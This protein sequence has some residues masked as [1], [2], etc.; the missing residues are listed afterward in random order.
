MIRKQFADPSLMAKAAAMDLAST[1]KHL[2]QTKPAVHIALTGGTS[3]IAVLKEL[4]PLLKD[5]S[6]VS[7]HF[8]WSD[9]RFVDAAS[10]ERNELQARRALL[11]LVDVPARNIH[12]MP[13]DHGQGLTVAAESF[14]QELEIAK[15]SIDV[16]LLGVGP[17]GHVA[18]LFPGR[19]GTKH[20]DFIVSE[21]DSPKPPP[22]R[23]SF[24]YY[25]LNGADEIWFVVAGID[26]A[27]ALRR[28]TKG[29]DL[30]AAKV[31]GRSQT[32]WY[33]DDA[34]ASEITS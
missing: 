18:S 34:A 29:V 11:D 27:D 13:A 31:L 17:D 14:A 22:Q 2:L 33:L 10:P 23:I 19:V 6:L 7:L 15:P 24:S 9:E 4:A 16:A 26:K 28:I 1:I 21:S 20:G 3:G 5:V 30:P 25:A 12:A 8:W 32:V